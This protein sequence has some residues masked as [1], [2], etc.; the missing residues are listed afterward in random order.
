M[1]KVYTCK[2]NVY[3]MYVHVYTTYVH[4]IVTTGFCGQHRDA[5]AGVRDIPW[6]YHARDNEDQG[7]ACPEGGDFFYARPDA[8][9]T[10]EAINK[11]ISGLESQEHEVWL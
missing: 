11:F 1:Y 8:A 4:D 2:Y 6:L 5:N 10:K 7:S 9:E 3:T